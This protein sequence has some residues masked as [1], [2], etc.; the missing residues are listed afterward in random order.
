MKG[1]FEDVMGNRPEVGELRASCRHYRLHGERVQ[2]PNVNNE[3]EKIY[4]WLLSTP[5]KRVEEFPDLEDPRSL[6]SLSCPS[7]FHMIFQISY[8]IHHVFHVITALP[9]LK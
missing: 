6:F 7:N 9:V 8:Y 3:S 4:S 2:G 5:S 1:I